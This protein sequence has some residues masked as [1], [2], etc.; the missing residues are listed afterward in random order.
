MS[1]SFH[2]GAYQTA[3][4][5]LDR[6]PKSGGIGFHCPL[7]DRSKVVASPKCWIRSDPL[8]RSDPLG[9]SKRAQPVQNLAMNFI[10]PAHHSGILIRADIGIEHVGPAVCHLQPKRRPHRTRQQKEPLFVEPG[11]EILRNTDAV[12]GEF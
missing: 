11:A 8:Q 1:R 6:A 3:S 10:S 4:E 12:A 9:Q 2:P 5:Q 7:R